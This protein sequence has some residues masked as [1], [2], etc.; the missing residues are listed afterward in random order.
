MT[1]QD[2]DLI[3]IFSKWV[4]ILQRNRLSKKDVCVCACVRARACA[5]T[6][7]HVHRKRF[8]LKNWLM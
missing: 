3:S 4:R 6:L 1:V 7:T 5:H 2:K 8:I